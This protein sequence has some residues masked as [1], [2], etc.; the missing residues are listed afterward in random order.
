[1]V[2]L[3]SLSHFLSPFFPLSLSHPLLLSGKL[4]LHSNAI[5]DLG[6]AHFT[7][8]LE[9]NNSLQIL[10]INDTQM[11]AGTAS[12]CKGLVKNTSLVT[13]FLGKNKC[14]DASADSIAKSLSQNHVL[15]EFSLG[16]N[17]V[18]LSP[19][20]ATVNLKIVY[21]GAAGWSVFVSGQTF[22]RIKFPAA[23]SDELE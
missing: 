6:G 18:I 20:W 8:A 7:H 15:K 23:I 19:D 14:S 5:G 9:V 3:F 1:M 11:D 4:D 16:D 22:A 13:C 2:S 17:Q 12:V 21:L 10:Y